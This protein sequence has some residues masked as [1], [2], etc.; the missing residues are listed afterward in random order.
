MDKPSRNAANSFENSSA[1]QVKYQGFKH[2]QSHTE[3]SAQL[4][5]ERSY[6]PYAACV[7]I[8]TRGG[9]IMINDYG[10][11]LRGGTGHDR[12]K[13][14]VCKPN[15]EIMKDNFQGIPH[16]H[17]HRSF[18]SGMSAPWKNRT[19]CGTCEIDGIWRKKKKKKQ[20]LNNSIATT[21]RKDESVCCRK[22]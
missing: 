7:L 18:V 20:T 13:K 14:K 10:T 4:G 15:E 2:V 16:I 11:V 17:E 6:K 3:V 8:Q 9:G 22:I 1:V 19:L 5:A 12:C 21:P